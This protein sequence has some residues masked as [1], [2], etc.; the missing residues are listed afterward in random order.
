MASPGPNAWE[1]ALDRL[2]TALRAVPPRTGSL[3]VTIYGDAILPRGGSL[4]LSSLLP[5]MQ[6][7]GAGPGVV[8]TAISRL[9]RDGL[10]RGRR[11]GRR[12]AYD[13]TPAG[14]A[15]FEAAIPRIYGLAS[16]A[17]DGRLCLAFPESGADRA[18]LAGAGFVALAPGILIA[19]HP[20]PVGVA[21]LDATGSRETMLAL[22]A[23]AWPLDQLKEDYARF[24]AVFA[25]M[26]DLP[27]ATPQ[28]ALVARVLLIHA[29]R[30]V[31]LRD[32]RL[33]AS[34]LPS[35]WPGVAARAACV[36]LYARL[37]AP[38][39]AWLDTAESGSGPLPP[40]PDPLLRFERA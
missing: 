38:S 11:A 24:L 14:R 31:A 8:R 21:T 27:P 30:R 28:D 32:P 36:S 9:S 39:E 37:G 17:W 22:S 23:R 20:A 18:A 2:L 4:A 16:V 12:S 25:D 6:R 40:G 33:P 13:L 1:P 29:W 3:I 26:P 35:D 19:P 10:L 7:L 34:L 5:L 15:E